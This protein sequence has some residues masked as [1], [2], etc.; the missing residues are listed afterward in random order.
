MRSNVCRFCLSDVFGI[1]KSVE[2]LCQICVCMKCPQTNGF[3]SI[4]GPLKP[5]GELHYNS[6]NNHW[7]A[8]IKCSPQTHADFLVT[9][10]SSSQIFM[11]VFVNLWIQCEIL[12][13]LF[14]YTVCGDM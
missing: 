6:N 13:G 9:Y 11:K 4:V 5:S 2:N 8:N 1:E 7:Y 12:T 10:L 3:N 14:L